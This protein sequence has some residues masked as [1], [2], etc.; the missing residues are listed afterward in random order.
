MGSWESASRAPPTASRP[1]GRR[2]EQFLPIRDGPYQ[3]KELFPV[4][5]VQAPIRAWP[6]PSR[7]R[8][9]PKLPSYMG[10]E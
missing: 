10:T 1:D 7:R 2:A 5:I 9:S 6:L 8:V 4:E 3:D